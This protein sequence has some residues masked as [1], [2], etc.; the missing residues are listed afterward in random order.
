MR[1]AMR[2]GLS[3]Q[4]DRV[5][6]PPPASGETESLRAKYRA[7]PEAVL[8][9]LICFEDTVSAL[10][11]RAVMAGATVLVNQ[12]NDAWFDGS[13]EGRQHHAQAVFR[14]IENRVPVVRCANAGVSAVIDATG[15]SSDPSDFFAMSITPRGADWPMAPYTRWGDWLFGWPCVG[16]VAVLTVRARRRR[17][18]TSGV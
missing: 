11:R 10:A 9:P 6:T 4:R 7:D 5:E 8:S 14:A 18:T 1:V 16:V 13:S 15:R 2:G 12:S 3:G 17:T